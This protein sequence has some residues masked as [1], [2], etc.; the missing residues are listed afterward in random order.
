VIVDFF[1]VFSELHT[2][3]A[4]ERIVFIRHHELPST[5]ASLEHEIIK[6]DSSLD[7]RASTRP[8]TRPL[9]EPAYS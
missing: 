9:G 6:A 1:K 2:I 7:A 4:V 3:L 5:M 8:W